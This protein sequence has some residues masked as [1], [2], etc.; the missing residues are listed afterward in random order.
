[1]K[2]EKVY[3][4]YFADIYP[5][6]VNKIQR[7]GCNINQLHEIIFWLTGY[8]EAQLQQIITNKTTLESFFIEAPLINP[9]AHKIKGI[10]CGYKVE[11]ITDPMMQKIRYLDKLVDELAKG[12]TLD[13][14]FRK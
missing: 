2:N 13:K 6:Y 3:K 7:N 9:N 4:M 8:N 14:I 12:K 1:M 10:I 11:E 5:L